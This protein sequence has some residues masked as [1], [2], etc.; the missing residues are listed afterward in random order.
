MHK[1]TLTVSLSTDPRVA[2]FADV[3]Y[4][5][6]LR[7]NDRQ[8]TQCGGHAEI[9]EA[10]DQVREAAGRSNVTVEFTDNTLHRVFS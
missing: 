3:V 4:F 1:A 5:L 10:I 8:R 7:V 2:H 9:A 6:D